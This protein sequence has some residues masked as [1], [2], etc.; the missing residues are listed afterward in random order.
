[1]A[2]LRLKLAV[3]KLSGQRVTRKK[4]NIEKFN[5][6]GTRKKSEEELKSLD[7][8][9]MNKLTSS[10]HWTVLKE[11]MLTK[12]EGILGLS[13]RKRS[14]DWIKERRGKK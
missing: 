3:N 5:H 9:R 11:V 10:E 1:V 4:C 12:S 6:G 13:Q 14:K 2:Q 8:E 7:Q